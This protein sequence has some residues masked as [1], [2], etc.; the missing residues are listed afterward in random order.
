MGYMNKLLLVI[1][2][3]RGVLYAVALLNLTYIVLLKR[4]QQFIKGLINITML[5]SKDQ[6]LR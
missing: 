6:E 2:K 5:Y 4:H 3:A 1:F